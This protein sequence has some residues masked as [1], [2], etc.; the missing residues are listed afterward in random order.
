[1]IAAPRQWSKMVG[2]S[3]PKEAGDAFP[4]EASEALKRT[5]ND[6]SLDDENVNKKQK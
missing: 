6:A 2:N 4:V 1:M 3:S 5:A